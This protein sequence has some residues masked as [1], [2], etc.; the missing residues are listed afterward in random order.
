M[1]KNERKETDKNDFSC[2]LLATASD[3]IKTISIHI[4][5]GAIGYYTKN[6]ISLLSKPDN[7]NHPNQTFFITSKNVINHM[8]TDKAGATRHQ[9]IIHL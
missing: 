1:F 3:G 4:G 8:T 5:D 2:T 9:N 6:K 7:P